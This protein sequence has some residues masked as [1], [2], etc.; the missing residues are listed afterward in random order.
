MPL[1][2]VLWGGLFF[3]SPCSVLLLHISFQQHL[4]R[5]VI[6][7]SFYKE[8]HAHTHTTKM[9]A[10]KDGKAG[11]QKKP[12]QRS[13]KKRPT[14]PPPPP[15]EPAVV[16]ACPAKSLRLVTDVAKWNTE[17]GYVTRVGAA[18]VLQLMEALYLC[19]QDGGGAA[20]AD[21]Q[22]PKPTTSAPST[23]F[24]NAL[25][26]VLAGYTTPNLDSLA[27]GFIDSRL[28][29]RAG[30]RFLAFPGAGATLACAT[31]HSIA[32]ALRIHLENA[33]WSLRLRGAD[34]GEHGSR[35]TYRKMCSADLAYVAD[36][37]LDA[38]RGLPP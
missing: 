17:T 36:A 16:T 37:L 22:P 5:T 25:W 21:Q 14:P 2:Y 9:P 6:L 34:D 19:A 24:L 32:Y 29:E 4:Y 18:S 3:F 13:D 30:R 31:E 1:K 7:L 20:G 8:A 23:S 27:S 12:P 11:K 10:Q 38:V 15:A 26:R 28:R 35:A 33:L